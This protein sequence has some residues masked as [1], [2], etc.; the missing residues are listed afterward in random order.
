MHKFHPWHDD[1]TVNT[2]DMALVLND[3]KNNH[4][5]AEEDDGV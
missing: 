4:D 5:S 3:Y 1:G 2:E